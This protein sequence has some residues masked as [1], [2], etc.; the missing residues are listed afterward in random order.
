VWI[1]FV[2]CFNFAGETLYLLRV[3]QKWWGSDTPT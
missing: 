1:V 2:S 3:W